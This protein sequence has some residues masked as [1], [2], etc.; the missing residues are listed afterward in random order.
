MVRKSFHEYKYM[1]M[2]DHIKAI[3]KYQL[4]EEEVKND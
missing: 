2:V 4:K 1:V 3:R